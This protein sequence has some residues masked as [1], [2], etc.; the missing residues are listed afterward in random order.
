MQRPLT[1]SVGTYTNK[2]FMS[3]SCIG[4]CLTGCQ[5]QREQGWTGAGCLQVVCA[6]FSEHEHGWRQVLSHSPATPGAVL[7]ADAHLDLR[8]SASGPTEVIK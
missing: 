6:E 8:V 5:G 3:G 7:F 1:E 2:L 4:S